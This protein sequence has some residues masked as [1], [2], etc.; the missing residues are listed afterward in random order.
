MLIVLE[1]PD[2]CAKTEIGTE[3]ANRLKIGYFKNTSEW[4][5]DLRSPDYFKNLL[6]YGATFL[7]DFLSQSKCSVVL[8][9]F[10]PSELVYSRIFNRETNTSALEYC[11]KKFAESGGVI[12]LC[13]RKSYNGITDD[14]HS[15][16]DSTALEK[17]DKEYDRFKSWTKCKVIEI[18]V[19][20]H[21]LDRQCSEIIKK[22]EI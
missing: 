15:F 18:F 19:D 20:D 16:I 8:D 6:E 21:N 3:L 10:Y 2:Q 12:V 1:G 17:L 11:D 4:T 9:R 14:L 22:L 7:T 5:A 13:R